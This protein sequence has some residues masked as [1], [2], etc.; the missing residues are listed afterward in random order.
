MTVVSGSDNGICASNFCSSVVISRVCCLM[1]EGIFHCIFLT[2]AHAA[3]SS[4]VLHRKPFDLILIVVSKGVI[5]RA[6]LIAEE[7]LARQQ[8]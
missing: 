2:V 3:I 8:L 6:V 4:D 7:A 1:G 5:K